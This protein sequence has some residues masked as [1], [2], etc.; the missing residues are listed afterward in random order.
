MFCCYQSLLH[1]WQKWSEPFV[2]N[3]IKYGILTQGVLQKRVCLHC[4]LEQRRKV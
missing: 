4:G 1:C 2:G 3:H